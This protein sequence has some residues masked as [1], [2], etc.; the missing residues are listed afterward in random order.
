[1][2]KDLILI[3]EPLDSHFIIDYEIILSKEENSEYEASTKT[4]TAVKEVKLTLNS[5]N[6]YIDG[7]LRTLDVPA[8]SITG[9]TLVPLR[10]VGESFV[11]KVVWEG[12]TQTI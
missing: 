7:Q 5:K 8:V 9:R 6:A 2:Y 10:F 1:M 12:S 3:D 4:I 11:A